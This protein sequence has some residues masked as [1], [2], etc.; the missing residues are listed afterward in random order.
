[1]FLLQSKV[2]NFIL[3]LLL[4]DNCFPLSSPSFKQLESSSS[5]TTFPF[6]G[7]SLGPTKPTKKRK[8]GT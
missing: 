8:Y 2:T 1:M 5:K 6:P 3:T 7:S 4:A